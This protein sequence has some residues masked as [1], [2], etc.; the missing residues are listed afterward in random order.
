MKAKIITTFLVLLTAA[1]AYAQSGFT[2]KCSTSGNTTTFEITRDHTGTVE[3]VSYRTISLSAL[4]GVHVEDKYGYLEFGINDESKTVQVG[5]N[6]VSTLPDY[7]YQYQGAERK[8]RFEVVDQGGFYLAHCDRTLS[9]GNSYK[10]TS[11]SFAEKSVT[12]NSGNS[13]TVTDAG[14]NQAIH[15]ININTYKNALESQTYLNN[16]GAKLRMKMEF[17]AAEKEDGYQYIQI[18]VNSD[19]C[20]TGAKN[21][22]PGTVSASKYMAG[23]GHKPGSKY[24]TYAKYAF[25]VTSA[26]NN[27]SAVD[28]AWNFSPYNNS[29][30]K[31]YTQKFKASSD[32]ASDGRLVLGS[33]SEV[34]SL[35]LRF[36]ASGDNSDTWY[37]K[38]VTA[39][40]QAVETT[41]PTVISNSYRIN[42][43]D[44][45]GHYRKGNEVYVSVAFSEIVVVTGTP[46][47]TTNWGQLNYFAGSGSNV[48]T[49][50]GA[51][52]DSASGALSVSSH[53]GTI[54]DLCGNSLLSGAISHDFD[55]TNIVSDYSYYIIYNL[56]GGSVSPSNPSNYTYSSSAI[57]LNIPTKVGAEFLGWTGTDVSSPSTA[58]VI[59]THSHGNRSYTANWYDTS[60]GIPSGAD[61]SQA[62]PYLIS[63]TD[64]L[65]LLAQRVNAGNSY[66]GKY[67][68][69]TADI[70]Y[71]P[72]SDWNNT[73]S[74]EHNFDGIGN[75]SNRHFNGYFDGGGHTISGIRIYKP[76]NSYVGLFGY[77]S[78]SRVSN[79]TLSDSRFTGYNYVAGIAG[80]AAS[81]QISSCR[82]TNTVSVHKE[83]YG[84]YHG[85]IVGY[86]KGSDNL[87]S[88]CVS[89]ATLSGTARYFGGIVGYNSDGTV[90]DCIAYNASI[91]SG[92][93]LGAIYGYSLGSKVYGNRYRNCNVGGSV[94]SDLFTIAL[95]D[96]ITASGSTV[97]IEDVQYYVLNSTVTLGYTNLLT[98][99][100]VNYSY[101]DGTSNHPLA[102][103][104]NTFSMP[105]S[106]IMVSAEIETT[107][108]GGEGSAQTPYT[109]GTKS[110]LIVLSAIVNAGE[111]YEGKYFRL[112]GDIDM[113]GVSFDGI[114]TAEHPFAGNFNGQNYVISNLT[115]A[116]PST[117]NVGLFGAVAAAG[118]VQNTRVAGASIT[119]H[120]SA[121]VLSGSCSGTLSGNYY[122]SCTVNGSAA[123]VGTGSGDTAGIRG[124]YA[125]SLPAGFTASGTAVTIGSDAFYVGGTTVTVTSTQGTVTELSWNDGEDHTVQSSSFAMPA[126]DISVTAR[127]QVHYRDHND[128]EQ[129]VSAIPLGSNTTALDA[130]W[131]V[132]LEDIALDHRLRIRSDAK[133]I[134]SD[135]ATLS[136]GTAQSAL[137][138][139]CL[140]YTSG[141][142]KLAIYAQS[143]GSGSL[144]LYSGNTH[145][146]YGPGNSHDLSIYG[147]H[148]T[149]SSESYCAIR[150]GREIFIGGGQVQAL[151]GNNSWEAIWCSGNLTLSWNRT[152]DSFLATS[153]DVE[154]TFSIAEGKCF[155]GSDSHYYDSTT[156]SA[157]L[158]ELGGVTLT[159]QPPVADITAREA[160]DVAGKK[161]WATFYNATDAARL[162]EGACAFWM[163]Y[164]G[165]LHRLGTDGRIVPADCPVIIISSE[166]SITAVKAITELTNPAGNMLH[167][168]ATATAVSGAYVMSS[169]GGVFG[170]Y[171]FTGT[172][173]AGKAYYIH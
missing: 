50:K 126:A 56:D 133:I 7:A 131:Y 141:D 57:T 77:C 36:D 146:V 14:Y 76:S 151:T 32:R 160:T 38:N 173:P 86:A 171:P 54:R 19:G 93:S 162:P 135:G 87:I 70:A 16:V 91:S 130:G 4:V 10:V 67:F 137:N 170:F 43:Y 168:T 55:G 45:Y 11:S 105:G 33:L 139:F 59:P 34:S 138:D 113:A 18:L 23:F 22:D 161:Y 71:S 3:T 1:A 46:Y 134:L 106:D 21:G 17:D 30:G 172:I 66:S 26:G 40:I 157:E 12:V 158:Q 110:Q 109:I 5:E 75:S 154:G 159:A 98:G 9:Y 31:L 13:I 104:V 47:L 149:L 65:N 24:T 153:Y 39:K 119:G 122:R 73:S 116:K 123:N 68:R 169:V 89:S 2:V 41:R 163:S 72:T 148:V 144:S 88:A 155:R 62:K 112:T 96:H 20:D 53:S 124:V 60:W 164:D 80:Y 152:T 165:S 118:T 128:V 140:D 37:A 95:G 15:A 8:Y 85:G 84:N 92:G 69:I 81:S 48:L 63:T 147:G 100:T 125:L 25:P 29:V 102:A 6:P 51:I 117:D 132:A 64:D 49:F 83:D 143:Q 111:S 28:P 27:C 97:S 79:L 74:T 107:A 103:G 156:P 58:V 108:F 120:S 61:G 129:T 35:K 114:G 42:H 44:I 101:H 150:M 52:G 94:E 121:G 167:G 127:I 90:Q 145:T 115:I 166:T 99:Q 136:I 78:Y 82:V 142:S